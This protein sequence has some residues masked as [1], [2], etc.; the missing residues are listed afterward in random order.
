[1]FNR[2]VWA[3]D[4]SESADRAL[5]LAKALA[6]QNG[7]T[8]V[9]VHSVEYLSGPGSRG[10]FPEQAD[11]PDV[12]AKINRQV[13][14]LAEQGI[15][16]TS[17]IVSG[18]MTGAA[19]TVAEV[20]ADE[21]ADLIVVGTRGHTALAGLLLGSVTQRLLHIAPCPVLVVPAR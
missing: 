12:E 19:H 10:A 20:A 14:E 9:A 6:S 7:S 2:I 17:K 16:A 21:G 11:E 1:V 3:T 13:S 4:G 8:I 15:G 5:D 18:G